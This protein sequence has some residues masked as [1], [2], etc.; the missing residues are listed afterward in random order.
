MSRRRN[1]TRTKW[2]EGKHRTARVRRFRAKH[3]DSFK[4]GKATA[5]DYFHEQA[6]HSIEALYKRLEKTS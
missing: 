2:G 4:G 3:P 5:K 1:H 6:D